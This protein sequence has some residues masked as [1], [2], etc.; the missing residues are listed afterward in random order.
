M[1][2]GESESI[3]SNVVQYGEL[4]DTALANIG[5]DKTGNTLGH[6]D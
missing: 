6:L 5:K 2:S 4:T 3:S 1:L